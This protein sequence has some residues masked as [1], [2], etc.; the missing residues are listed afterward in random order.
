MKGN[1]ITPQNRFNDAL[2]LRKE[3]QEEENLNTAGFYDF[4][5]FYISPNPWVK[6][7]CVAFTK[8]GVLSVSRAAVAA[9]HSYMKAFIESLP[10]PDRQDE[11]SKHTMIENMAYFCSKFRM[12]EKREE[13]LEILK[14]KQIESEDSP[15]EEK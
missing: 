4:K 1:A 13:D 5:G 8:K 15:P 3:T 7:D 2:G 14:A 6:F 9:K 12:E 10:A 11:Q